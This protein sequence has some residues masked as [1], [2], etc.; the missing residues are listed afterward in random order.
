MDIQKTFWEDSLGRWGF[1]VITALN[2]DNRHNEIPPESLQI[3]GVKLQDWANARGFAWSSQRLA[4]LS[5]QASFDVEAEMKWHTT[6]GSLDEW[7]SPGIHLYSYSGSEGRPCSS[8]LQSVI[9]IDLL[10]GA[11]FTLLL[12]PQLV[13][14]W[15]PFNSLLDSAY[16]RFCSIVW[17]WNWSIITYL[18]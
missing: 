15:Y 12:K 8:Q 3:V 18:F 16:S 11:V 10:I 6:P 13:M 14:A 9:L 5:M 1:F 4:P 7:G 2:S 17:K